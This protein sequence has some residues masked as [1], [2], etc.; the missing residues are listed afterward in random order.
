MIK[1]RKSFT[2]FLLFV[3]FV[4]ISGY[5]Y[6]DNIEKYQWP[7][8]IFNGLSGTFQ[9]YRGGHFHAG[10]DLKTFQKTGYPVLAIS[11]GE[12]YKLRVVKRG[13]GR[14][15]YLK[16]S[17]GRI[18]TYFHLDRFEFKLENLLK[19]IQK[20]KGKKYI[21]NH[22][23]KNK[24]F[25]KKGDIIAFTG[26]TGSGYP[27]LHLELK[28]KDYNAINTMPFFKYPG[29]DKKLP[30]IKTAI[31]KSNG[32]SLINGKAGSTFIKFKPDGIGNYLLKKKLII[33]GGFDIILSAHDV[34][35]SGHRVS[36]YNIIA[37]IDDSPYYEIKNNV[38]KG[39]D[40][41]QIGFMYDLFYTSTSFYFYNLFYQRG[42]ELE[43]R[44][45]YLK[46]V[47]GGLQNGRHNLKVK[48]ID[49]FG[50]YSIGNIPFIKINEPRIELGKIKIE[51]QSILIGIKN[52]DCSGADKI[53]LRLLDD[54]FNIVST[55]NL[56][57]DKLINETNL[58]LNV[59]NKTVKFLEFL[60]YKDNIIHYKK[61]FS[62]GLDEWP[63]NR[64][65][66]FE[67]II[68][69]DD[70]YIK[71]K[72]KKI[73]S[74]N[75]LLNIFQG[76]NKQ[77]IEPEFDNE[78]V[79]FVFKPLNKA[80]KIILNFSLKKNGIVYSKMSKNIRIIS[81]E[82]GI[83]QSFKWDEFQADFAKRSVREPRNLSINKVSY[84]SDFPILSQ[85]FDLSPYNF[86][87]LDVVF[88][89]IIKK[90]DKPIQVSLFKYN[91]FRKKWRAV[92]SRYNKSTNTFSRKL[93]SSGTFALMRDIFPP[94]I[95]FYKPKQK[96]KKS[97]NFLTIILTDRGKG[98]ND[99]TI[100]ILLNNRIIKDEFD[101][102]WSRVRIRDL[103]ALRRGKNNIKIRVKDYA[104][105]ETKKEYS[106]FLK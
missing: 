29:N 68:N 76:E 58:K 10:I 94:K 57:P 48:V 5:V 66:R 41:N 88:Y 87:F 96:Y 50:N 15:L 31:F 33:S 12:I 78:G 49:Y 70:I 100:N 26:E 22:F 24:I 80:T 39:D 86:P 28:D 83:S 92:Y 32:K 64:D 73:T 101:P 104:G 82:E 51:K 37:S 93:R 69:R 105:Y 38:F 55:G 56:N 7:L 34:N 67:T 18:S 81:L 45:T 95:K 91:H 75:I 21:G 52:L 99:N 27:H 72:N 59:N 102:D 36:P 40:N 13:S 60:V 19:K 85:Q 89:K 30:V 103:R 17:D 20:D 25:Y 79:Y 97:V 11:D 14:A 46:D 3:C 61:K 35:D 54:R 65:I 74:E 98:I 47:F 53:V 63:E 16:H 90:V 62:T 9:E 8:K 44:K 23:L 106:F 84:N 42:F 6:A 43:K 1:Y 4:L 77:E 71:I 2:G